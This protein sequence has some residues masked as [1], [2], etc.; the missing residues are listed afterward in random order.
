MLQDVP[1]LICDSSLSDYNLL[2][3]TRQFLT[4]IS[5]LCHHHKAYNKTVTAVAIKTLLENSI[6]HF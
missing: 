6:L 3:S 5:T 2:S 1:N 4:N